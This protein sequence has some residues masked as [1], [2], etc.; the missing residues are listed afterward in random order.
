VRI[1]LAD[2][3]ENLVWFQCCNA[4]H[5]NNFAAIDV[6]YGYGKDSY[7]IPPS[8]IEKRKKAA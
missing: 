7:Q 3:L 5:Y 4:V 2:M 6:G 8:F 1:G